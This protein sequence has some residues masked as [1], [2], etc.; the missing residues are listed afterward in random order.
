VKLTTH[1]N[2]VPSLR[3]H[4]AMAPLSQYVSWNKFIPCSNF[5]KRRR[6]AVFAERLE[7]LQQTMR[8]EPENRN[9]TYFNYVNEIRFHASMLVS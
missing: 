3:T 7:E 1:L 9:D 4:G 2:L 8:L 6:I 5:N